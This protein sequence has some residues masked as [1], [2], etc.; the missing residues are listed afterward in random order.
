MSALTFKFLDTIYNSSQDVLSPLSATVPT[1]F[2]ATRSPPTPGVAPPCSHP[3][4]GADGCPGVVQFPVLHAAPLTHPPVTELTWGPLHP[5]GRV[6]LLPLSSSATPSSPTFPPTARIFM[7]LLYILFCK[8]AAAASNISGGC[9]LLF[10]LADD[11]FP[12]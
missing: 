1:N 7:V 12:L 6:D 8:L 4:G 2:G 9:W 11:C 3:S 10:G 5:S